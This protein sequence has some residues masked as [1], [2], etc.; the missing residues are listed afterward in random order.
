MRARV[1]LVVLS[2]L[3]A[4]GACTGT[5]RSSSCSGGVCSIS[6][7]GEQTVEVE[8]GSLERDLRV[9]AITPAAVTVSARGDSATLAPGESA[10]VGGLLVRVDGIDGRDVEL[11]VTRG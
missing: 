10:P 3:L 7:S 5:S 9:S 2:A 6:L 8:I 1:V 4:L 11:N